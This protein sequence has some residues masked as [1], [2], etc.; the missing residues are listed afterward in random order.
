MFLL[1]GA[2]MSWV[3]ALQITVLN[4]NQSLDVGLELLPGIGGVGFT[5]GCQNRE[6]MVLC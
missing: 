6:R 3:P 5:S 4:L 2:D 1:E